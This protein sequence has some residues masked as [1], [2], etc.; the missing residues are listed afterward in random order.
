[1]IPGKDAFTSALAT[2]Q[3]VYEDVL[4]SQDEVNSA[5]MNLLNAMADLRL[6]PDKGLLEDLIAQ[7][8]ALNE[9]DYEAQS[10]AVMRH[11]SCSG[12]GSVR[13]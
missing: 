11:G 9:A 7:A 8:E 6:I 10:F 4:A 2:A 1:M 12:E 5:W 3:E 13:R